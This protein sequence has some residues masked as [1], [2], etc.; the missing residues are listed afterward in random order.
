MDRIAEAVQVPRQ[1]I[2]GW[3]KDFA[4]MSDSDISAFPLG[5]EPPIYNVWKQQA[6]IIEPVSL[7]RR[8]PPG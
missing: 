1:T 7:S 8:N 5:F 3:V 4:E 2:D 6:S